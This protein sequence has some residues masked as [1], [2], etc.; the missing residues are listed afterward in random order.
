MKRTNERENRRVEQWSRGL[1]VAAF[2]ATAFGC[3][4]AGESDATSSAGA[5]PVSAA[6][7]APGVATIRVGNRDVEVELAYRVSDRARGLMDR[8]ELPQDHGM[9]FV[10]PDD[11][12]QSY[13]TP[14]M[15]LPLTIAFIDKDGKI[16]DL[17]DTDPESDEGL[18]GFAY[19]SSPA[20]YA[21]AMIQ[22]WFAGH[23]I[24]EG[25]AVEIPEFVRK[26]PAEHDPVPDS[27]Y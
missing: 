11:K 24:K 23:N 27:G 7:A 22:S 9:L 6:P 10:Y 14:N 8:R 4:H 20:R 12:E 2:A 19:S 5:P 21:L 25:D 13:Y 1:V 16:T 18:G 17:V 26:L 3:G 15:I